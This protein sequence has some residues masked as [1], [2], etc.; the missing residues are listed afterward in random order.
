MHNQRSKDAL[1]R[2]DADLAV[3]AEMHWGWRDLNEAPTDLVDEILTRMGA[4]DRWQREKNKRD[5]AKGKGR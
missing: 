3:M 4:R 2:Y 5:E 1:G